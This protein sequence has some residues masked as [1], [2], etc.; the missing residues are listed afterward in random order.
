MMRYALFNDQSDFQGT[1]HS[2]EELRQ[3]LGDFK[4]KNGDDYD[5]MDT[6]DYIRSIGW[7]FEIAQN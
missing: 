4:Y 2:I 7:F 3:F 1:F 5:F 6:F